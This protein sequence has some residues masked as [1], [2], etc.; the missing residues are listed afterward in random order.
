MNEERDFLSDQPSHIIAEAVR[1]AHPRWVGVG[2]EVL[3]ARACIGLGLLPPAT[4][5]RPFERAVRLEVPATGDRLA[6]QERDLR[7]LLAF[8]AREIILTV[9]AQPDAPEGLYEYDWRHYPY[10]Y[11]DAVR[12]VLPMRPLPYMVVDGRLPVEMPKPDFVTIFPSAT[13]RLRMRDFLGVPHSLDW[14]VGWDTGARMAV[15]WFGPRS[16]HPNHRE[17]P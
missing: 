17:A 6:T 9:A 3:A 8:A 13:G 15:L 16:L 4:T 14:R 12:L 10:E 2:R 11:P 1:L 7:Q 5:T